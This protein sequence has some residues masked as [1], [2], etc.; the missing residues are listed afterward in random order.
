MLVNEHVCM[1]V[2]MYVCMCMQLCSCECVNIYVLVRMRTYVYAGMCTIV[3]ASKNHLCAT[4]TPTAELVVDSVYLLV[5]RECCEIRIM[6]ETNVTTSPWTRVVR[7]H[8]TD[9]GKNRV[10]ATLWM[11]L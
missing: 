11:C 2:W 5:A 3:G 7:L 9:A 1:Y 10:H 4:K 6:L 8:T